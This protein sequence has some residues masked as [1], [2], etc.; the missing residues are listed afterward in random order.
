MG[1]SG[2]K[3]RCPLRAPL[4]R[5][6]LAHVTYAHHT[7]P[8]F[9]PGSACLRSPRSDKSAA[10]SRREAAALQ[11]FNLHLATLSAASDTVYPIVQDVVG[12]DLHLTQPCWKTFKQHVVSKGCTCKRREAT[13]AE[14]SASGD[15]RKSKR[16]CSVSQ[17]VM[18]RD[19]VRCVALR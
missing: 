9:A 2:E 15:H 13:P 4:Y 18:G 3:S 8:Y 16:T 6:P 10:A 5:I 11:K 14:R 1:G 17:L 19:A 12:A 7:P